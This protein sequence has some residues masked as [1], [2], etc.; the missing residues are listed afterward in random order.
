MNKIDKLNNFDLIR[1]FAALQVVLSHSTNH[2]NINLP[3]F[4]SFLSYFPGVPIFFCTSGFLITNSYLKNPNLFLFFRNRVLRLYPALWVCLVVTIFLFIFF[5]II[6]F[7]TL[8]SPSFLIWFA[9]QLSFL[10]FY[11]VDYLRTWGVGTPN[12]SLWTIAVELQ[13]YLILPFFIKVIK[14]GSKCVFTLLILIVFILISVL[15]G[16]YYKTMNNE[17][18]I[19]KLIH[20][21]IFPYFFYFCFGILS[22]LFWEKLKRIIEKKFIIWLIIY[23][24]YIYIFSSTLNLF[25]ISYYP[26]F[27]GLV[28]HLLLWLLVLSAAFTY[29]KLSQTLLKGV[30]ISYGIYIY[31]ML[32]VNSLL[33]IDLTFFSNSVK[34]LIALVCTIIFGICSWFFVEVPFLRKKLIYK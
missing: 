28:S 27:F 29:K 30:D 15:L 21:S 1:L 7:K 5:K 9:C 8:Y 17:F 31:H 26:N 32:V 23:F 34:L 22:M 2:L 10:Q 12:G 19:A 4:F 3:H 6:N 13:F 25:T 16:Q 33:S 18:F 20:V 14:R 11:T 24:L